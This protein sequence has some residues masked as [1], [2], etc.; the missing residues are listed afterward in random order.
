MKKLTT[1]LFVLL[2]TSSLAFAQSNEATID[3][4]GDS[5]E[6]TVTQTGSESE[7]IVD[8]DSHF[9]TGHLAEVTQQFGSENYAFVDQDQA[10]SEAFVTQS[11]SENESRSKQAGYNELTVDQIGSGN[12][13]GAYGNYSGTAYQKN[14]TGIFSSDKNELSLTQV[15]TDHKAGVWQEHHAEADIVQLGGIFG[16]NNKADVKQTGSPEEDINTAEI[17]QLGGDLVADINQN[18]EGNSSTVNSSGFH[19]KAWTTQTGTDHT[20][21][22]NQTG[23]WNTADVSQ[24]SIG[25]SSTITQGGSHHSAGV[26]QSGNNNS[27]TVNQSGAGGIF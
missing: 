27:S 26:T 22:I 24:S 8:Q 12:V 7:V 25:N 15:G 3:Q 5:H 6:A 2:F 11:G 18:G 10:N 16:G 1:L 9:G 13:L 4:N 23:S 19:G 20:S 14:G 21:A 17:F